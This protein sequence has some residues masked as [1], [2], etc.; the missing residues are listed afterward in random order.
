MNKEELFLKYIDDQLTSKEKQKVKL[1]LAENKADLLLFEK[2][3]AKRDNI[4]KEL[5]LLNPVESV[6]ISPFNNPSS[7]NPT[8]K[9]YQIK[10]WHYAAIAAIL[11]GVYFGVKQIPNFKNITNENVASQEIPI[12]KTKYK[13]LD[14]YISPNRCWNQK[15]LVWSFIENKH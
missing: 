5:D 15:Q 3:K 11:I 9:I 10:L 7:K 1:M 4:I 6:N 8:K 12:S 13:E 14:C 2:V